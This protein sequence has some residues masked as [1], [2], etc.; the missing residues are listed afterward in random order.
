MVWRIQNYFLD[1]GC[2]KI[3]QIA[4]NVNLFMHGAEICV[5]A[6]IGAPALIRHPYGIVIGSG[7]RI[8]KNCTILQGVTIGLSNVITSGETIYPTLQNNIVLGANCSVLGSI[9]IADNTLVGAH[10]L[11]LTNT[12]PNSTYFG[13]P[14]KPMKKL[15]VQ[16]E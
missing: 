9:T 11:V 1:M 15:R 14:A 8:G 2:Y 7:V 3:S 4:S 13:V 10:S 12:I 6:R 16:S 5:G